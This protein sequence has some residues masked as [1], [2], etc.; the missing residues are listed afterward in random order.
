MGSLDQFE[1][2]PLYNVYVYKWGFHKRD[3]KLMVK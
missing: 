1:Q 2:V 3:A